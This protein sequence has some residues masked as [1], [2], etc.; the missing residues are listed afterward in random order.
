MCFQLL[1]EVLYLFSIKIDAVIVRSVRHGNVL[2]KSR[3]D[4]R[5]I[6]VRLSPG[7][8][9]TPHGIAAIADGSSVEEFIIALSRHLNK[10]LGN[11]AVYRAEI[12]VPDGQG[13][14]ADPA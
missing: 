9:K 11:T 12:R 5:E 2:E 3:Q 8:E 10:A 14:G 1:D 6:L 13:G 4:P 7:I